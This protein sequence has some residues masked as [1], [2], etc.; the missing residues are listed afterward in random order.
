MLLTLNIH[1][2]EIE[3]GGRSNIIEVNKR[4]CKLCCSGIEDEIHLLLL[5]PQLDTIR[6][7]IIKKSFSKYPHK[8]YIRLMSIENIGVL[9]CLHKLIYTR[10][11]CRENLL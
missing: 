9:S 3:I 5:C 1:R 7:S 10:S 6:E 8:K 4:I 11:G 2:L